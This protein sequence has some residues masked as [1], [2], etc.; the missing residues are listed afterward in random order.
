MPGGD[1]ALDLLGPAKIGWGR[2]HCC[3]GILV[4][5]VDLYSGLQPVDPI[6]TVNSILSGDYE[7][8]ICGRT[9][10]CLPG[11]AALTDLTAL[12]CGGAGTAAYRGV[13]AR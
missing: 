12:P 3:G 9:I 1:A 4:L 11:A 5:S 2:G 10:K 6:D 8:K 13:S 7:S